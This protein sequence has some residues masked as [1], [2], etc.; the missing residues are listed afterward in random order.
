M[1]VVGGELLSKYINWKDR[2][3]CVIFADGAG[4]V[5][6]ESREGEH[7]V[8][9][10][11]LH[12][13]GSMADFIS[14]PGGGTEHPPSHEMIDEG[15]HLIHMKGNE[16]FKLAIRSL[17]SVCKEVCESR[18]LEPKDVDLFVPHQANIRIINAVGDRL[19]HAF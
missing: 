7:G 6:L 12:A 18:G 13:D 8:L 4:A 14:I 2:S 5:V 16:T 11:R 19:G 10:T 9:E 1:L 3:T 15:L 17:T